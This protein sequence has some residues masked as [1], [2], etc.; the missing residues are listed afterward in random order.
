MA[1][2]TKKKKRQNHTKK[3]RNVDE[4][5]T[6]KKRTEKITNKK[7]H[8][9]DCI[10]VRFVAFYVTKFASSFEQYDKHIVST[11]SSQI[12]SDCS[13]FFFVILGSVMLSL[14]L[15]MPCRIERWLNAYVFSGLASVTSITLFLLFKFCDRFVLSK[16]ICEWS[17]GHLICLRNNIWRDGALRC[18]RMIFLFIKYLPSR[19]GYRSKR[20]RRTNQYKYKWVISFE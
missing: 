15:S 11:S 6:E 19:C 2:P 12:S 3:R 10:R 17:V 8:S 7:M 4:N 14:S 16:F 20:K 9:N 13:F 1:Q 18:D 5:R